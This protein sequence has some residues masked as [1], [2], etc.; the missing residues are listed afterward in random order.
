MSDK[1]KKTEKETDDF[2]ANIDYINEAVA[3]GDMAA[4]VGHIAS[5]L[6]RLANANDMMYLLM[7][8]NSEAQNEEDIQSKAEVLAQEIDEERSRRSFIGKRST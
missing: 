1:T 2:Q 6:F 4:L 5:S 3:K 8:R 7:R